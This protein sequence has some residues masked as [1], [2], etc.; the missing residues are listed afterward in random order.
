MTPWLDI[1]EPEFRR[2]AVTVFQ[3]CVLGKV[4]PAEAPLA[5]A[6]I[7]AGGGYRGQWIWD[8]HQ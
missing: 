8:T 1:P 6:W 4:F 2:F 7:S 3:Q 5:Q